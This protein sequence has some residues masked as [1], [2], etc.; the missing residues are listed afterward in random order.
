VAWALS[1]GGLKGDEG[2]SIC[3]DPSGNVY[4][5]GDFKSNI[6]YFGSTQLI[7][8]TSGY[9]FSTDIFIIKYNP[10]G[11]IIWAKKIGG[12]D[13]E[14]IYDATTDKN[15]NLIIA[16]NFISPTLNLGSGV[17]LT[18]KGV[19]SSGDAFIA[20][21]SSSG[22]CIWA[23]N[24]GGLLNDV[25]NGCA[26][27]GNGNIYA[28]GHFSSTTITI[29]NITHNNYN[30]QGGFDNMIIKYDSNGNIIWSK[31]SGG[32]GSEA[33]RDIAVGDNGSVYIIGSYNSPT[34]SI[35]SFS[36]TND[37]TT[38][39]DVFVAKYDAS[40]GSEQW[41]K[42]ISG[43]SG[44]NDHE[45]AYAIAATSNSDVIIA[46]YFGSPSLTIGSNILVNNAS[47]STS[48]DV[49]VIKYN[50]NGNE[51]WAKSFGG[52]GYDNSKS[53]SVDNN[54]NCYVT[55]SFRSALFPIGSTTLVS[56]GMEDI[57][58]MKYDINGNVSWATSFDN[59]NDDIS[60][61]ICNDVNANLY[62]TG[63]YRSTSLT[64]GAFNLSN[65]GNVDVFVA[66]LGSF[67]TGIENESIN[68]VMVYPNPA[69]DNITVS[70]SNYDNSY[71][72]IIDCTG[73]KV[74]SGKLNDF[75]TLIDIGELTSG[76]YL[77]KI[78]TQK[79]EI[80]TFKIMKY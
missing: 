11:V 73:K 35:G 61:A 17:I 4:V 49:F 3:T 31:I 55:G 30:I 22:N 52:T 15:G 5:V 67:P 62:I 80:S 51:I 71:Y 1:S 13:N 2:K 19:T 47:S 69:K 40:N 43:N 37:N 78:S 59:T 56:S 34:F 36:L 53:L 66:R 12:P 75:K 74:A 41:A 68:K 72:T 57:Y 64:M 25:F 39:T 14:F 79:D 65:A 38:F 58:I 10:S 76:L 50:T 28:A 26:V 7:K 54:S 6:A 21:Y 32:T 60:T 42:K 70:L 48:W 18:N 24:E 77:I 44:T 9:S 20:K 45:D 63:N 29:G 16:G 27:D 8:D 23:K 46:G 33:T